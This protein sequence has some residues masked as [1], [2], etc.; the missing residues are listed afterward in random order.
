[1]R[2]SDS[3]IRLLLFAVIGVVLNLGILMASPGFAQL[4]K[5]M[6]ELPIANITPTE[7]IF[8]FFNFTVPVL[9]ATDH[10]LLVTGDVAHPLALS[11]A[12]LR[13]MTPTTIM[14]TLRCLGHRIEFGWM[15]NAEWTGVCL[16]DVLARAG[17]EPSA[18]GIVTYGAD[19]FRSG[20]S[21]TRALMQ[22]NV[23]AWE[24]NGEVLPVTLGYPLRLIAPGTHGLRQ[25]MWLTRIEVMETGYQDFVSSVLYLPPR[26]DF[27]IS[28]EINYPPA[29]S[30]FPVGEPVQVFGNT[31]VDGLVGVDRVEVSVDEGQSWLPARLYPNASPFAWTLWGFEWTPRTI[32][33]VTVRARATAMDGSVQPEIEEDYSDG[34]N[35][36]L[37]RQFV[38]HPR[39]AD[40][41]ADGRVDSLDAVHFA[42]QWHGDEEPVVA[43]DPEPN[44]IE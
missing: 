38:I 40:L 43:G 22:E 44:L 36:I 34:Y 7:E 24:V 9:S 23:L 39:T 37:S 14:A 13:A 18:E 12:D 20:L 6:D 5:S 35:P 10:I 15:A 33:P 3:T 32:G 11:M 30:P 42:A 17:A 1:M 16:R 28:S 29:D 27:G 31:Y 4:P 21:M 41:N 2:A 25:T 8:S 26:E 19:G